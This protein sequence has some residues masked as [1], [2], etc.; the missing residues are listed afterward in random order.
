MSIAANSGDVITTVN[1]R[2]RRVWTSPTLYNTT[3]KKRTQSHMRNTHIRKKSMMTHD[4]AT[5]TLRLQPRCATF[6]PIFVKI[7]QTG[8]AIFFR[9]RGKTDRRWGWGWK[10]VKSGR[11]RGERLH[12]SIGFSLRDGA[13]DGLVRARGCRIVWGCTFYSVYVVEFSCC[14]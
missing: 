13:C 3:P 6:D 5:A 10:S 7:E 14:L 9:I 4:R 8:P 11:K 2:R 1:W 12:F